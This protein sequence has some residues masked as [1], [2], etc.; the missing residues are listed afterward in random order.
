MVRNNNF[1]NIH[2]NI[3]LNFHEHMALVYLL[4]VLDRTEVRFLIVHI[5]DSEDPIHRL[6]ALDG[7]LLLVT[8]APGQVGSVQE[9]VQLLISE[10]LRL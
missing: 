6:L 1:S 5:N 4:F 7:L 8:K 9:L 3:T 2:T 10:Y